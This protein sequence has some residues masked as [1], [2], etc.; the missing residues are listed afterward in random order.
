MENKKLKIITPE[1]KR[2]KKDKIFMCI[3]FISI[4]LIIALLVIR[5]I[6]TRDNNKEL[7]I[8][9]KTSSTTTVTTT[10][11]EVHTVERSTENVKGVITEKTTT[12]KQEKV[13]YVFDRDHYGNGD[14]VETIVDNNYTY[15]FDLKGDNYI[16]TICIGNN[17]TYKYN[18]FINDSVFERSGSDRTIKVPRPSI[19]LTYAPNIVIGTGNSRFEASYNTKCR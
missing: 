12:M 2:R 17:S 4:V 16:I 14:N 5:Y 9:K 18:I 19:D 13:E 6:S 11:P 15:N 3:I 7:L 1:E 10:I 8:N